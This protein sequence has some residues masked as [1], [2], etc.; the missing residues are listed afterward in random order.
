MG[1]QNICT[2]SGVYIQSIYIC[3]DTCILWSHSTQL[4][5]GK[6]IPF[7]SAASSM[8][9]SARKVSLWCRIFI[10]Y[11]TLGL[12]PP[13]SKLPNGVKHFFFF[14]R[15]RGGQAWGF[16]VSTW[17]EHVIESGMEAEHTLSLHLEPLQKSS[18]FP[19]L[20]FLIKAGPASQG[21]CEAQ[22]E[23][24]GE[25]ATWTANVLNKHSSQHVASRGFTVSLT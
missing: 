2:Y 15:H 14:L 24:L 22:R 13:T 8:W 4:I 3:H 11:V 23:N 16:G 6:I 1:F 5:L 12:L 18:V 19:S 10:L 21:H 25:D 20:G 17:T 9:R 7:E